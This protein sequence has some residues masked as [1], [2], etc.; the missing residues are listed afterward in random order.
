MIMKKSVFDSVV[1][2]HRGEVLKWLCGRYKDLRWDDGE[3][4]IQDSCCSLWKWASQHTGLNVKD[5]TCMWKKMSRDTYTHWLAKSRRTEEWDD[6]RLQYG[7]EERDFGW[8]RGN[9]AKILK[10]ELFYDCLESLKDKDRQLMK[11]LLAKVKMKDIAEQLGYK[12]EQVAKNRKRTVIK[13]LQSKLI[14]AA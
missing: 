12:N 1:L 8:D 13:I 7:W 10:R 9:E 11:L 5:L 14:V 2:T 3:D 4:I 6:R